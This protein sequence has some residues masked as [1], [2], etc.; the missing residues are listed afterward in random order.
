MCILWCCIILGAMVVNLQQL[1][2][3]LIVAAS[4]RPIGCG[5][6]SIATDFIMHFWE[7]KIYKQKWKTAAMLVYLEIIASMHGDLC[8]YKCATVFK[9]HYNVS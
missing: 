5:Y 2:D 1:I 7:C 9:H 6:Q 4:N 8:E 3:P